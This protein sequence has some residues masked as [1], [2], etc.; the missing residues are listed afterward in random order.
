MW[1]DNISGC[2]IKEVKIRRRGLILANRAYFAFISISTS[3]D[4]H[5]QTETHTYTGILRPR[6]MLWQWY[7]VVNVQEH[8]ARP[9]ATSEPQTWAKWSGSLLYNKGIVSPQHVELRKLQWAISW[10][11]N[12]VRVLLGEYEKV[13]YHKVVQWR[14]VKRQERRNQYLISRSIDIHEGDGKLQYT[15]KM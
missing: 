15:S 3:R 14:G 1:N 8:R 11:G 9:N 12:T 4:I 6:S 2:G 5:S 7:L 13:K 10:E